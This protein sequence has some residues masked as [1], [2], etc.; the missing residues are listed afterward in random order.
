[1]LVRL[2]LTLALLVIGNPA[3]AGATSHSEILTYSLLT[4]TN[5]RMVIMGA[6]TVA[7]DGIFAQG[8][9][10]IV[11][12]LLNERTLKHAATGAD[13]DVTCW[14]IRLL[15]NSGNT[16]YKALVENAVSTYAHEK[17][18]KFGSLALLEMTKPADAG[19]VA[20]TVSLDQ[21]R[22][23]LAAQRAAIMSTT[24][25]FSSVTTG[26]SIDEIFTAAGYPD[27]I[28]ETVESKGWGMVKIHTRSLQFFYYGLGV[29]DVDYSALAETHGWRVVALWY[30]VRHN[31]SPYTGTKRSEAALVMTSEPMLLMKL[32]RRM[33]SQRVTETELLDRVAERIRISLKSRKEHDV[34]ALTYFCRLLGDSGNARYKDILQLAANDAGDNGIRKHAKVALEQFSK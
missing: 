10:D 18:S 32:S 8:T 31:A 26:Q 30:D 22:T 21:L 11:A 29:V 23:D 33:V 28:R 16:R 27:E 19:Y 2:L 3:Y 5:P 20:G 24:R 14:L 1:M 12:E 34:F 6:K 15:G 17:V 13:L 4:D 7:Q 25:T 9:T